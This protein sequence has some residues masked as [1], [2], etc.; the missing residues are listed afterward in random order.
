MEAEVCNR[1]KCPQDG[2]WNVWSPWSDCAGSCGTGI[3]TRTRSCVG[4]QNGGRPCSGT[5]RQSVEC[6]TNIICKGRMLCCM[7]LMQGSAVTCIC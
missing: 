7:V 4:Q 3:I 2:Q 6:D 1:G 5:A